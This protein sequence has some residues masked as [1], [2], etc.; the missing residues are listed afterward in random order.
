[1]FSPGAEGGG[2]PLLG[3]GDGP[4]L[5]QVLQDLLQAGGGGENTKVYY[6]TLLNTTVQFEQCELHAVRA[7]KVF[8][9]ACC[10]SNRGR[11]QQAPVL[12][13]RFQLHAVLGAQACR[14]RTCSTIL[15]SLVATRLYSSTVLICTS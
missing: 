12:L 10:S 1:M 7:S 15:Y 3:V 14:A 2:V 9:S 4:R 5:G 8:R 13:L 6:I 11:V